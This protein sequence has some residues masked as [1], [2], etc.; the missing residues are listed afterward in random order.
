MFYLLLCIM[1]FLVPENAI[2][3]EL[4]V[5]K[6]LALLPYDSKYTTHQLNVNT[7]TFLSSFDPGCSYESRS[8]TSNDSNFANMCMC[9]HSPALYYTFHLSSFFIPTPFTH[10][11]CKDTCIVVYSYLKETHHS[12]HLCIMS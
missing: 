7:W 10:H 4:L 3:L 11:Q 6:V 9:T 12:F 1:L 2:W 8:C 5:A